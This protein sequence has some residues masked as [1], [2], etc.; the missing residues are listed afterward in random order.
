MNP[1]LLLPSRP[2]PNT[3]A[4]FL[5]AGAAPTGR[6]AVTRSIAFRHEVRAKP[7]ILGG[8][9]Y[10]LRGGTRGTCSFFSGEKKEPKKSRLAVLPQVQLSSVVLGELYIESIDCFLSP[11]I[12][13]KSQ[14]RL[15][16]HCLRLTL[17]IILLRFGIPRMEFSCLGRLHPRHVRH[18]SAAQLQTRR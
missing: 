6:A 3:L 10:G 17:A 15:C 18:P 1:R 12:Q 2:D 8:I 16:C 13:F 14:R 9:F 7:R 4:N 5:N 11:L